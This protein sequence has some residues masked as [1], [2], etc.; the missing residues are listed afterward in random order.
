MPLG[1]NTNT[2]AQGIMK[3]LEV[4]Q[5]QFQKSVTRLSSGLRINSAADDPAALITAQ[6][7][8][9]QVN[10]LGQAIANARDAMNLVQTAEGAMDQIS[11][12]LQSMRTLALH[13]ANSG[14]NDSASRDAD[15]TQIRL[16][17]E[18]IDRIV[19]NTQFGNKKLIDGSAGFN[20]TTTNAETSYVSASTSTKAGTYSVQVTA[21]AV[22][23]VGQGES[24][25]QSAVTGAGGTGSDTAAVGSNVT[26]ALSGDLTNQAAVSVDITGLNLQQA[27][28]AINSNESL[29][30]KVVASTTA[31]GNNLVVKSAEVSTT[32]ADLSVTVNNGA[33][34]WGLDDGTV[35]AV[36][37]SAA[38]SAESL[39]N[40]DSSA[41]MRLDQTLTFT[42]GGSKSVAVV[43]K[44]G[45][46]LSS[47]ISQINS[48]V[49]NAGIKVTA[50]LSN[51]SRLTLTNDEYGGSSTV[52]NTV[53]SSLGAGNDLQLTT[54]AN[55]ALTLALGGA[56]DANVGTAGN[57]AFSAG[58][59]GADVTGS[60][61]GHAATGAGQILTG[62]DDQD[63]EGLQVRYSGA[64]IP[65]GNNAG[66][67]TVANNALTMQIG[68]FASQTATVGINSLAAADLG[69]TATGTT[70]LLGANISLANIDVTIG[71]DG[72]GAQDAL[73]IIDA[74]ISQVATARGEL[75]AFQTQTLESTIRNSETA[76]TN[77]STTLA[78]IQD[79]NMAKESVAFSR[80]QILQQQSIS[81]LAQANQAPQLLLRLFQ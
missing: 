68:A 73:R 72:A 67:V 30:G 42:D 46:A 9:S 43:L 75:G 34:I 66:T 63:E 35:N 4:S 74:A 5:S 61:N 22:R 41:R 20:G 18:S 77:L 55:S 28:D 14:V 1:I 47:A 57:Q 26:I 31:D 33:D 38:N 62:A 52:L 25:K 8:Q 29:K 32:A 23:G 70:L 79:A 45:T 7:Y 44:A 48:A 3:N 69:K 36:A 11:N 53:A 27:V 24:L 81:M 39:E 56:A 54:S 17:L 37:G 16:A 65:P 59:S 60:I 64:A 13:A 2:S 40:A 49:D 19:S 50:S 78:D 80:A 58:T 76:Q 12:Q 71:N 21:A 6:K 10:G 51:D 15:Q